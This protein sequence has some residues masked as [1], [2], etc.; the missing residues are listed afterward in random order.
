MV[1][2]SDKFLVLDNLSGFCPPASLFMTSTPRN[3]KNS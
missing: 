1:T 2:E 3:L